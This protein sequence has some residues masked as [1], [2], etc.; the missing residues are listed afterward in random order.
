MTGDGVSAAQSRHGA[1]EVHDKVRRWL[2]RRNQRYTSGRRRLVDTMLGSGKPLTLPEIVSLT[3]DLPQS[4][5]Y[6]NLDVLERCGVA[7]RI[8]TGAGHS[9][10]EL[11]EPIGHHHH[12]LVCVDCDRIA[13][14]VLS[15]RFES[16]ADQQLGKAASEAGFQLTHHS[17]DLYGR[18]P[19]CQSCGD[20]TDGE[21]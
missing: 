20:R 2:A 8:S 6:R 5:A 13:D 9:Y 3:P 1:D 7:R 11:A 14:I 12:H 17:I 19:G 15:E 21:A 18:C 4:S 16:L 10:F